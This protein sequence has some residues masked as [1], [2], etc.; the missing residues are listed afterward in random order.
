MKK[1]EQQSIIKEYNKT[2]EEERKLEAEYKEKL[3]S[4]RQKRD[5]IYKQ[6]KR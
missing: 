5:E 4:I 6:F 3:K 1:T 2:W